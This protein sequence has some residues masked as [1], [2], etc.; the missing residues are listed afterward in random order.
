MEATIPC[1]VTP[2]LFTDE[3]GVRIADVD[4]CKRQTIVWRNSLRGIEGVPMKGGWSSARLVVDVVKARE[5]TALIRPLGDG[6]FTQACATVPL[7]ALQL[8]RKPQKANR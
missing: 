4:G 3:L 7:G 8:E 1:E 5:A 6:F 2:G